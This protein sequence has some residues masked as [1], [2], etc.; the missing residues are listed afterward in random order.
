MS[1]LLE[2]KID[3]LINALGFDIEVETVINEAL[4]KEASDR[5]HGTHK[6][7]SGA[8]PPAPVIRDYSTQNIKLVKR[9]VKPEVKGFSFDYSNHRSDDRLDYACGSALFLQKDSTTPADLFLDEEMTE[10][11]ANPVQI[12]RDGNVPPIWVR[13]NSFILQRRKQG[14]PHNEE[15]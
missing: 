6:G 15:V 14:G 3:A 1:S 8:M 13:D 9:E 4:Y 5:H 10:Q 11:I 2:K 7:F 12:D